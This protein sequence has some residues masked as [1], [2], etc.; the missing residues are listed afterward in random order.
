MIVKISIVLSCLLASIITLANQEDVSKADERRMMS[1]YESAMADGDRTSAVKYVLD[2]AEMAY[3]ENAPETIRLTHHYGE[4]LYRDGDYPA[5][6]E[7]LLKALERSTAAYGESGGEAFQINMNIGYAYAQ[8]RSRLSFRTRYFDRALE[9][10]RERGERESINYVTTLVSIAI[11]LMDS[12][13]LKGDY[14]SHLSD[15]MYSEE[16]A[17][18]VFPVEREY[19][20]YYYRAEKY[21]LEAAEIGEKLENLD[22]YIS[23]KIA[24]AHAK[25]KVMETADLGAVPMGV[26]GYISRGTE[27]DYYERE[28]ERLMTAIDKLAQDTSANRIFLDAANS[29]LMEIAWLDKD[30]E[31]MMSMCSN[32]ML[33]SAPEYPPDRLYEVMEGGMVFAPDIGIRVSTNIFRPLRSRGKQQTDENGNPIKKPYFIPV[34][35]D[36]RLMAA[37]IHAPKVTIEEVRQ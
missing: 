18:M 22:E 25:L 13:S 27:K 37:L 32:G 9:I 36:G 3:G 16:A 4:L 12:G 34:C 17:E 14:S 35:I 30:E 23:S 10:L 15:S 11:N 26:T 24:I 31:R 28:Q 7:V 1:D 5:A 29:V 20:N 8:W 2:Y 6:T 19:S 21:V 33:N